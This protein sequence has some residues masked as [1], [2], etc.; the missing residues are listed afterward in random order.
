MGISGIVNKAGVGYTAI[1]QGYG[2]Y[3]YE[4]DKCGEDLSFQNI[5]G[6]KEIV[7]RVH[8]DQMSRQE[9]DGCQQC[10]EDSMIAKDE[11]EEGQDP[12]P[13]QYMHEQAMPQ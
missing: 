10:T 11:V 2:K 1:E 12:R 13:E 6:K 9:F 7:K 4:A 3:D 8:E 5:A